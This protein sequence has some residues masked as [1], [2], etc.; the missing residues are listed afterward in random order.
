M[1]DSYEELVLG[2]LDGDGKSEVVLLKIN[3]EEF[4]AK[5]Q[6][7]KHSDKS[8][9]LLDEIPTEYVN[10]YIKTFIGQVTQDKIGLLL[11]SGVGAHSGLTELLLLENGKLK[12]VSFGEEDDNLAFKPYMTCSEDIDGDGILEISTLRPVAGYEDASM[13]GTVWV[14]VWYKW[15]GASDLVQVEEGYANYED[16]YYFR[17]PAKW[18]Q[19]ITIDRQEYGAKD[20]WTNF[21]YIDGTTKRPLFTIN[22]FSREQWDK[23][24]KVSEDNIVQYAEVAKGLTRVYVVHWEDSQGDLKTGKMQLD[25]EEIKTGLKLIEN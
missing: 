12:K 11:D 10:G 24:K 18:G 3:R 6:V 22:T 5:A 25:L 1:T 20:R 9:K 14:T 4:S 21:G 13:A 23:M 17:F 7:F 8:M 19:E 2:D 15:D 16:G